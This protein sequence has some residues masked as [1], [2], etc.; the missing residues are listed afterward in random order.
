MNKIKRIGTIIL[1]CMIMFCVTSCQQKDIYTKVENEGYTYYY[2]EEKNYYYITGDKEEN[3][4]PCWIIEPYLNGSE[5]K[6]FGKFYGGGWTTAG[7]RVPSLINVKELYLPY[8]MLVPTSL[9]GRIDLRLMPELPQKVFIINNA[10]D[11]EKVNGRLQGTNGFWLFASE[12]YA[13]KDPLREI[14]FTSIGY[15]YRIEELYGQYP[16]TEGTQEYT[17]GEYHFYLENTNYANWFIKICKA[18]TSYMFNYENSPNDDY[19]FI[20]DYE[21]GKKIETVPYDPIREG[22]TFDGWYKEPECINA[23]NFETDTLPETLYN[24]NNE[25]VYQETKLYAKWIK[26]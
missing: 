12:K 14:Y 9:G 17:N 19:F 24:E 3:N 13:Q 5:V 2:N 22:Y 15:E 6:Y 10:K 18:N 25:E 21:Y 26:N 7:V 1:S 20:R 4:P 11:N 23:W 16:W 8:N